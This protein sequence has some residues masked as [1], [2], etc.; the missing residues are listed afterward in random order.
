MRLSYPIENSLSK[1]GRIGTALLMLFSLGACCPKDGVDRSYD[2][3]LYN[4]TLDIQNVTTKKP[5][6]ILDTES[7]VFLVLNNGNKMRSTSFLSKT[8]PNRF[9]FYFDSNVKDE[10]I[11]AIDIQLID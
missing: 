4:I 2:D 5:I 11:S 7:K 10:D 9:T 3:N 1:I 8:F 6:D